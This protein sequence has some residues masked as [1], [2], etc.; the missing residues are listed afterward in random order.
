MNK[1]KVLIA[2]DTKGKVP[3]D[4]RQSFQFTCLFDKRNTYAAVA[5]YYSQSWEWTYANKLAND[6]NDIVEEF[7]CPGTPRKE[8]R[9]LERKFHKVLYLLHTHCRKYMISYSFTNQ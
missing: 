8:R 3:A 1:G 5:D 4:I 9:L 6:L 7:H 2:H